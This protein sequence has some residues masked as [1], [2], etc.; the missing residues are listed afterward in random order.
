VSGRERGGREEGEWRERG[1]REEGGR[2]EGGERSD[3]RSEASLITIFSALLRPILTSF[4]LLSPPPPSGDSGRRL[5][6]QGL[7]NKSH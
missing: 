4:P 5:L 7:R 6:H 3:E 2:R 1:G